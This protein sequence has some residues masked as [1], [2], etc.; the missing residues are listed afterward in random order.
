MVMEYNLNGRKLLPAVVPQNPNYKS[1]VG[2]FIYEFVERL[3]GE[4]KAPK[5]TGMLIDLPI[6]EIQGYLSEFSKLQFKI[7]EANQLLSSGP[8]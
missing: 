5:I 6:P 8:Q 1:Q 3:T 4:E 7:Q 2:E